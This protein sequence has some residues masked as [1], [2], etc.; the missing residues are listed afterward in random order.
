[1]NVK[2]GMV[3]CLTKEITMTNDPV[4]DSNINFLAETDEVHAQLKA[5]TEAIKDAIKH[6]KGKF[7][8]ESKD[9]VSK[10]EAA[11]YASSEYKNAIDMMQKSNEKLFKLQNQ[12]STANLKIDVWRT[13]EAS[14][15]K[16]NV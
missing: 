11:F 10:A 7:V 8:T 9:S 14:R 13:L 1:M 6:A 15:R 2:N 5:K 16:G 3:I 4:I 12:R